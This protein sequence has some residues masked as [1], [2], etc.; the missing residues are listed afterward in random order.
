MTLPSHN[1]FPSGTSDKPF[2]GEDIPK[3]TRDFLDREQAS[4]T[5]QNQLELQCNEDRAYLQQERYRCGQLEERLADAQWMN[6]LLETRASRASA[7]TEMIRQELA[8]E[9]A[10]SQD[11]ESRVMTLFAINDILVKSLAEAESAAKYS[12][13]K[14]LDAFTIY[15]ENMKQQATIRDLQM[16]IRLKEGI[17]E[18][19][20]ATI[21]TT[22]GYCSSSNGSDGVNTFTA[23]GKAY[24]DFSIPT[25]LPVEGDIQVLD[26][27]D[28]NLSK[29]VTYDMEG[30]Q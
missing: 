11:L 10:K 6:G 27:H 19:L 22:F 28:E 8:M 13:D 1:S 5:Y 16:T 3:L 23:G 9:R 24:N 15:L 2:D 29:E 26:R 30:I 7:D 25:E 18:T 21:Q 20:Q 12:Q 4:R 14:P 17:I